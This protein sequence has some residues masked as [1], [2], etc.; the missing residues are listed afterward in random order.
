MRK[1]IL[2]RYAAKIAKPDRPKDKILNDIIEV[3]LR[4]N[5]M[6]LEALKESWLFSITRFPKMEAKKYSRVQM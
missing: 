6:D 4:L 2:A 3:N 1:D 5:H